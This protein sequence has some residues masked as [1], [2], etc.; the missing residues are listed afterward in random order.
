MSAPP[1]LRFALCIPAALVL[2]AFAA[3]CGSG[4]EGLAVYDEPGEAIEADVGESFEL[5][6]DS[7]PSTGYEWRLEGRPAAEVIRFDGSEYEA[8]PGSEDLDG[9]GGEQTLTFTAVGEG[10]TEIGL[11][12]VF[13]GGEERDPA[14][15]ATSPVLVRPASE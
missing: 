15:T 10:E 12:Y 9:G 1:L 7:N 6:L 13:T 3:G 2:A 11:E 4:S 8:D 5:V 14:K